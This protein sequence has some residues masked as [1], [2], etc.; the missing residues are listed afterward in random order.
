MK[1]IIKLKKGLNLRLIGEAPLTLK[2]AAP[3]ATYAL[4]PT[5][6]LGIVPR[7]QV[8]ENDH[9]KIGD[10]LFADKETER[11]KFVAPVSGT[12]TSIVRGERR[13][14][15]RIIITPDAEQQEKAKNQFLLNE[16]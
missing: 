5:D 6:F 11:I 3:S 15:L 1:P 4:Q 16:L 10:T 7:L 2:Q 14:L 8:K 12:V 9:V 13:K